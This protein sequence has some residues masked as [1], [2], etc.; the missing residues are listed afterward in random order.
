MNFEDLLEIRGSVTAQNIRSPV[1]KGFHSVRLSSVI[2]PCI[3]FNISILCV[4]LYYCSSVVIYFGMNVQ[5]I[6]SAKQ[7]LLYCYEI[8]T[9]YYHFCDKK[10]I[11]RTSENYS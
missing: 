3:D 6:C 8:F 9:K 11:F 4:I 7:I 10:I 5:Q 1:L 2:E